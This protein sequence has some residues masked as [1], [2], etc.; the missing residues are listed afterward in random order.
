M[1]L[2]AIFGDSERQGQGSITQGGVFVAEE[3]DV[4]WEHDGILGVAAV[5]GGFDM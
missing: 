4:C 3:V 1:E 5:A 2:M